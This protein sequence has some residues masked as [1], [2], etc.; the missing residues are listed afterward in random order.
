MRLEEAY[1]H[2]LETV[3]RDDRDRYLLCVLAPATCRPALLALHAFNVAISRIPETVSEPILG[4]IRL[5]W[6]HEAIAAIYDK[7]TPPAHP[8]IAAL[9]DVIARHHL[10]RESFERML[11]ARERDLEDWR[12]A[13]L[14]ELEGYATETAGEVLALSMII[15]GEKDE[16]ALALGRTAGV[17]FGLVGILRA[18]AYQ[19]H[20]RRFLIPQELVDREGISL[21]DVFAF[22]QPNTALNLS[23]AAVGARAK[24][25]IADVVNQQKKVSL[26]ARTF[27]LEAR[28]AAYHLNRLRAA[29]FNPFAARIGEKSDGLLLWQLAGRRL[30]GRY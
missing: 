29:G 23:V 19:A 26:P 16:A 13:T 9:T 20:R 11:R 14:A 3:R 24:T 28:I 2:C 17:A 27:L 25:L 5:Q 21:R 12:P 6:W 22:K 10:G 30:F 1:S 4:Q 15:L 8:I 18:I 7:W